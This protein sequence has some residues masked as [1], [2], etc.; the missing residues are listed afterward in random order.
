MRKWQTVMTIVLLALMLFA[1]NVEARRSEPMKVYVNMDDNVV[2]GDLFEIYAVI[3][4]D[5]RSAGQLNDVHVRVMI[6]QLGL[7]AE[8]GEFDIGRRDVESKTIA[9]DTWGITPGTYDVFV[10]VSN[11]GFSRVKHRIVTIQ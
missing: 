1:T 8:S 2:A 11:D 5:G 6:P 4:N 7:Y 10:F 3:D 9:I